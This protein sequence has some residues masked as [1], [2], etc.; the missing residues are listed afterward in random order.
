METT[1]LKKGQVR[2]TH[3]IHPVAL[4]MLCGKPP[5]GMP[6]ALLSH[7]QSDSRL[8]GSPRQVSTLTHTHTHGMLTTDLCIPLCSLRAHVS[9][10]AHYVPVYPRHTHYGPGYPPMFTMD[11]YIPLCPLRTCIFLYAHYGHPYIHNRPP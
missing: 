2:S 7:R 3:L 8:W 1:N 4:I 6:T 11:L 9:P 10:H 5:S